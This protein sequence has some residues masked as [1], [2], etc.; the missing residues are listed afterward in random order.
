MI[1][2]IVTPTAPDPVLDGISH[3]ENVDVEIRAVRDSARLELVVSSLAKVNLR[4]L[5]IVNC[6]LGDDGI[7]RVLRH[8]FVRKCHS[9]DFSANEISVGAIDSLGRY[10]DWRWVDVCLAG[11]DIGDETVFEMCN[12]LPRD[13]RKVMIGSSFVTDRSVEALAKSFPHL[14]LLDVSWTNVSVTGIQSMLSN[15]FHCLCEIFFNRAAGVVEFTDRMLADVSERM[16]PISSLGMCE[17]NVSDGSVDTMVSSREFDLRNIN[18]VGTKVSLDGIA[19][20]LRRWPG[21][22]IVAPVTKDRLDEL[23]RSTR[24]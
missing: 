17:A 12:C 8:G 1:R 15:R 24:A 19:K 22:N 5:S 21:L 18:V 6:A 4:H 7:S 9:V 14:D 11:N 10:S 13:A 20:L 3:D 2:I 16:A 23:R